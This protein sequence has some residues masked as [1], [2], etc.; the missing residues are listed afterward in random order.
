MQTSNPK[1]TARL[2]GILSL[3]TIVGGIFAQGVVANRLITY[4]DAAATANNILAN[5]SLFE[6]S[7]AVF[8]IEMTC[9]IASVAVFYALLRPV[10]REL[11]LIAATI[12][13]GGSII[14]TMSRLFY[15]APLFVLT[16]GAQALHAFNPDQLR[17]LAL[18]LFRINDRGAAMSL[19]F[20]GVSGLL[21]GYLIFKSTYLPRALGIL[22]MIGSAGWL[23][24]LYPPLRFPS[25][26]VIA[27]V[28]ILTAAVQIFW[29]IVFG[30]D[31]EKWKD[32]SY[33]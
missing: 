22:A 19:G 24:F 26:T 1:T 17:A 7:F 12:N 2:A 27:A 31:A 18:L 25:F 23:R 13:L 30:V 29:L 20:F 5:R 8:L 32:M 3:L 6:L 14:K 4:S 21:S 11:A 9:Q 10:N 33:H 16:T 15:I 28:A